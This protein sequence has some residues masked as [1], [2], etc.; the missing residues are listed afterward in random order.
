MKFF[1]R[2][3]FLFISVFLGFG[4]NTGNAQTFDRVE[5]VSGLGVLEE[6]NGVAVADYD[7]DF[8]LDIFVVAKGKEDPTKPKSFSRLFRNNND[9]SFTDVT[10]AAGL[11]GLLTI[12]EEVTEYVGLDGFKMGAFWGDYNNDGFPD[13]LFTH[14]FKVQLFLNQNGT[15]V[16]VT[17]GVG[18]TVNSICRNTGAAWFDYNNDGF[19]DIYISDWDDCNGNSLYRNNGNGTFQNV[20]EEAGINTIESEP[21]FTPFPFDFNSDGWMDIYITNDLDEANDLMINQNGLTFTESSES[22]GVDTMFDDMG[23]TIGDYNM[24]GFF[25]FFITAINI[26]ALLTNNGDNTF[27]DLATEMNVQDSDWAWGTKFADFDL[28]G[29]EDLVVV[30]GYEFEALNTQVNK[31]YKNQ[32]LEGQLG[33][34]DESGSVGFSDLTISVEAVDF[35]YDN[36]GDLDIFVTNSD[37]PSMLFENKLLNFDEPGSMNWF[38]VALEGTV[39]NRNAIGTELTLTTANGVIKRY[40]TGVGFLGQSLQPV[41]FGLNNLSQIQELRI[42]WPSGLVETFQ[43]LEAN[44]IV[45]VIEAQGLEVLDIGPS[46]KI[47]GCTDPDS[48]SYNPEATLDDGSCTYLTSNQ[49]DGALSSGF[50]ST[51]VYSYPITPGSSAIWEVE[52]GEILNGQGSESITVRWGIEAT[53]HVRVRENNSECFSL[54]VELNVSLNV[55]DIPSDISIARVWNE[56]LLEAIRNDF[57]RPT[58]HARNLFHTSVALYDAWSIYDEQARPYLIGNDVNGFT[59][60]LLDFIPIESIEDSQKKAMSYA[61]Y[62]LLTHRFQ[63]SPNAEKTLERFDLIME[64]LDY[65]TEFNTTTLYEFGNAAAL[66]NYIAET[67]INF[68]NSDGA[69]ESTSY[70]NAYYEPVNMPLAPAGPGNPDIEDP[71]RWQE[72]TLDVFIDQSG[73]P[74]GGTTVEFLS[75]EWGNVWPF[76]MTDD[77]KIEF[78]RNGNTFNVYNNPGDPPFLESNGLGASSEAYKWGFSL[79]SIWGSHLDPTDGIIWDISPKSIGNIPEGSFPTTY[80]NH[81]GFYNLLEGGDPSPGHGINP[82]TGAAYQE[83]HVPR[84]DYARVL[85]E[86]WAD[87]PDSETPPGH[88]FTLLNYVNDHPNFEKQFQGEGPILEPLEWDVKAY[89]I[90]GGAMHDAAISSWSI[91]GY[92]DYLRPISAIRYMTDKGQS[93][94]QTLD[95]YD[96]HGIPLREGYVEVVQDGD[97]L[98]GS[99]NEHLGKIKLFTWRG[100]DY[101]NDTET[102]QAGVGWIL[103]ENWWPYQRPTFVTPPFAGYVSGHSTYSRAA[104]EVLTMITG[105]A[106]FPGGLGEFIAK[107]NEFLVFEEGPSVDVKLQWATYRDASDQCSLSRIWGGIHPPADDIPGRLIGEKIGIETFN[108]ALPYFHSEANPNAEVSVVYPNPITDFSVNITNTNETDSFE[109]FDIQGRYIEILEKNYNEFSGTTQIR[110]P[111]T[112]VSGLYILKFNTSL[113]MVIVKG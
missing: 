41:H 86:F 63:N 49:I 87:G 62:R 6:N 27:T 5:T 21:S 68:G 66:G 1:I 48:C 29:D 40:Y 102:D 55:A 15:F 79:V 85:A 51:E 43:D 71:N 108:F 67:L 82:V 23:I 56:A 38:K 101:I 92:Y 88:W 74:F 103:A 107:K 50:L 104:A 16:E 3:F 4:I 83:Q 61:A 14:S 80:L 22:Y 10:E 84:G 42:K 11:T 54:E 90:L 96:P 26:N 32:I 25:D 37:Q 18:I 12:E 35:D 64:Q 77:D 24:D 9:G 31:Y 2:N 39:S 7:G 95:N 72:L 13:L 20:S 59:S 65:E 76:A 109:F 60:E 97:P 100:H 57:A 73:N 30:N 89:F 106:F 112:T 19:L 53:G 45:K 113:K 47:Y 99:E 8:D 94:D 44:T 36:D 33:F 58:V 98:A 17:E 111:A 78:Q 105:D 28:D 69:R 75:P 110:I 70:D 91:K 81:P 93:S 34:S 52:G 46:I